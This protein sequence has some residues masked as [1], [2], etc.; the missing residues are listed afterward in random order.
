[1]IARMEGMAVTQHKKLYRGEVVLP[2]STSKAAAAAAQI[3]GAGVI[4][5]GTG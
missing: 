2:H 1:M 4:D 5:A 3:R